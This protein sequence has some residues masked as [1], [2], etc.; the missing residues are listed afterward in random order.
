MSNE[1]STPLVPFG[2]PSMLAVNI[3]R[4]SSFKTNVYSAVVNEYNIVQLYKSCTCL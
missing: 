2:A 1:V 3:T 4:T